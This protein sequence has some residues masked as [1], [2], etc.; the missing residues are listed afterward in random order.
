MY[1][2]LFRIGSFEI[3]SFGVMVALG[4][5]A[6]LWL[7]SRELRRSQLPASAIDAARYGLLALI[8]QPAW[9]ESALGR[10]PQLLIRPA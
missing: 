3:T 4:A 5:L 2:V 9:S 10:F 8:R 7:F 6:G 1:P